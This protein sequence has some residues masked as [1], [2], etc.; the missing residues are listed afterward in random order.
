[1]KRAQGFC[2]S[3]RH[4]AAKCRSRRVFRGRH[5][6]WTALPPAG[7]ALKSYAKILGSVR[8]WAKESF[9]GLETQRSAA[10]T[11]ARLGPAGEFAHIVLGGGVAPT[12]DA[13]MPLYDPYDA[14]AAPARHDNEDGRV[15]D[16]A[17]A[18]PAHA[19][20]TANFRGFI[21]R[22]DTVITPNRV[23]IRRTADHS[24]F[25]VQPAEMA[26]WLKI[27]DPPAPS[28]EGDGP[29]AQTPP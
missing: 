14:L 10:L 1:M 23:R 25:I 27:G 2:D 24:L 9:E 8:N 4:F 21:E 28:A 29:F 20:V 3:W 15:I 13:R 18:R 17:S 7:A 5:A 22:H 6:A 26:A 16:A 11:I 12:Q 19:L